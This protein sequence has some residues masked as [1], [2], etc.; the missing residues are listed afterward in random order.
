M[1]HN[2]ISSVS[3]R[4]SWEPFLIIAIAMASEP[5]QV[6]T[7]A[8]LEEI[9]NSIGGSLFCLKIVGNGCDMREPNTILRYFETNLRQKRCV[10]VVA[11]PCSAR[12]YMERLP[13]ATNL[14]HFCTQQ[15]FRAR[16]RG[17]EL[18]KESMVPRKKLFKCWK[19]CLAK[20][21]RCEKRLRSLVSVSCNQC[22]VGLPR[23]APVLCILSR[24]VEENTTWWRGS[25]GGVVN[26]MSNCLNCCATILCESV[27]GL[28]SARSPRQSGWKPE[29]DMKLWCE[30]LCGADESTGH[31][32][33]SSVS[34]PKLICPAHTLE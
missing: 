34:C 28:L 21:W 16:W 14:F 2:Q 33:V 30:V 4:D 1:V 11:L 23:L 10:C 22:F 31:L 5:S 12:N 9:Y 13:C 7:E 6:S 15:M 27:I 25:S 26:E 32:C 24:S 8:I 20:G 3:P 17:L 29:N 19:S 18:P